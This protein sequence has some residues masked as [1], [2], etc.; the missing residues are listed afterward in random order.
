M[1]NVIAWIGWIFS[2]LKPMFLWEQIQ[3]WTTGK[4]IYH[5]ILPG[6]IQSS[7]FTSKDFDTL[8]GLG[9]TA[10]IDLE[11]AKDGVPPWVTE[12]R[13]WPIVD[14]PVLPDLKELADVVEWGYK[15]LG[16]GEVL[17]THCQAG[18]NRSGLVDGEIL[19]R[20]GMTGKEALALI[21]KQVPGGLANQVFADYVENS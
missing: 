21:K 5:Q 20:I 18:H 1:K 2:I 15:H 13:Y 6:L 4:M 12:Y 3:M 9:I 11:G 7:A 14:E 10:I 8:K 16:P 17:L 19:K